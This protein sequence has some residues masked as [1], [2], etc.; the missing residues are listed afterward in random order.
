M[1]ERCVCSSSSPRASA[2]AAPER[3]RMQHQSERVCS[4]RASAYAA[5][6]RARMQHQSERVCSTRARARY[7]GTETVLETSSS[8]VPHYLVLII[9]HMCPYTP[10]YVRSYSHICVLIVMVDVSTCGI[11]EE[12]ALTELPREE[13]QPHANHCIQHHTYNTTH[14]Y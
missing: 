4:T 10:R 13:Q 3:A 6:E 9:L 2:Y 7:G 14:I 8:C 1:E 5:P 11:A 12:L